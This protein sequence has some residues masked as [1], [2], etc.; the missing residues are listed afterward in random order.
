[1]SNFAKE[2]AAPKDDDQ[3]KSWLTEHLKKHDYLLAFADNGVIWG[4]MAGE[5]LITS[6]DINEEGSP[7]L[8]GKTLQQAFIFNGEEEI[9]LFRDEMNQWQARQVKDGD[10]DEVIKESQIL[11]GDKLDKDENQSKDTGFIRLL[12]ERKGMPPQIF[13]IS[14]AFDASKNCV[15]LA[16]H[17]LVDYTPDGE[18]FIAISRLAGL[19]IGNKNEEV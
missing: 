16:V 11:W 4:K 9:R 19:R 1:M 17:H 6:H 5:K 2:I 12:A 14:D 13:P 15:R 7:E 3:V 18:A 8:R 10:S